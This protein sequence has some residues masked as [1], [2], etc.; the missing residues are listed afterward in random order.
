MRTGQFTVS[1]GMRLNPLLRVLE[2][3][4]KSWL[5]WNSSYALSCTPHC[6]AQPQYYGACFKWL[7]THCC[8]SFTGAN[9]LTQTAT[10]VGTENGNIKGFQP[11]QNT[12][13][14]R[15]KSEVQIGKQILMVE[16][17]LP[18]WTLVVSKFGIKSWTSNPCYV[19]VW[20]LL[21]STS[22]VAEC[23]LHMMRDRTGRDCDAQE[24]PQTGS[25][26]RAG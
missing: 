11:W 21:V 6:G 3:A 4:N 19:P 15:V 8:S 10:S 1:H 22:G 9:R 7:Q 24:I 2:A 12:A 17:A 13:F 14:I 20:M 16:K 18:V 5:V 25:I 26:A 23:S